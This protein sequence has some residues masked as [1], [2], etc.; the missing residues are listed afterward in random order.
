MAEAHHA[1]PTEGV[2]LSNAAVGDALWL[3]SLSGLLHQ[4]FTLTLP[5]HTPPPY[6][7]STNQ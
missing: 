7:H 4:R 1:S 6:H 2:K 3:P 5:L